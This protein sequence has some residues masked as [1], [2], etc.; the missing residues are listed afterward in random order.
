MLDMEGEYIMKRHTENVT[1]HAGSELSLAFSSRLS[2]S[3]SLHCSSPSS[4]SLLISSCKVAKKWTDRQ[5]QLV[6]Q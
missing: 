2:N 3:F 5:L 1:D 4:I 6:R